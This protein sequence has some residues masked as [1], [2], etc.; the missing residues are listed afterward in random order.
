M[1]NGYPI[2]IQGV[3]NTRKVIEACNAAFSPRGAGGLAMEISIASGMTAGGGEI[4][5]GF[6]SYSKS[7]TLEEAIEQSQY[8]YALCGWYADRGVIISMDTHGWLPSAT[9]PLSMNIACQIIESCAAAEQGIKAINPLVHYM[10]H[11]AQDLAWSRVSPRTAPGVP[12]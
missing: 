6:G 9:F 11:M 12:G 4:F 5:I 2:A 8:N 7:E 1:L 3:K 10:G